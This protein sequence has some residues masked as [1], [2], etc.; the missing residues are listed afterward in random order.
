MRR[1]GIPLASCSSK[2]EVDKSYSL[3]LN[4]KTDE[5]P[6]CFQ[7]EQNNSDPVMKYFNT[8]ETTARQE[9][10]TIRSSASKLMKL[11]TSSETGELLLTGK[12]NNQ[13][14]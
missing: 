10:K 3:K 14:Q 6:I 11:L 1:D 13:I 7:R 4:F 8:D 12:Q 5:R 2:G 9:N